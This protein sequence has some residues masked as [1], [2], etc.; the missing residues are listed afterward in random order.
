MTSFRISEYPDMWPDFKK[1]L[2]NEE[3]E[4][5]QTIKSCL[6]SESR[7]LPQI[8]G[9]YLEYCTTDEENAKLKSMDTELVQ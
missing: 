1:F 5:Y 6:Y 7:M 8:I 9:E 2:E 4:Q 3:K